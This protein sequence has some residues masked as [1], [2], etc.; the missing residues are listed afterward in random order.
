MR[1]LHPVNLVFVFIYLAVSVVLLGVGITCGLLLICAY[2]QIELVK[3]LWLLA[4]PPAAS[5]L[6]NI[7]LIELYIKL[8]RR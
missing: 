5:L 2:Y 3:H 7:F 6:I 8:A 4:I 1:G